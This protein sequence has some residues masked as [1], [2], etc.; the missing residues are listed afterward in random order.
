MANGDKKISFKA[1]RKICVKKT[2]QK[3]GYLS[4]PFKAGQKA[5]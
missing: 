3:I 1:A 2:A 4:S 5:E